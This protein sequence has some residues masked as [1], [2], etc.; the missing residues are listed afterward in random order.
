MYKMASNYRAVVYML[1][2][3]V[4]FTLMQVFVK[5]VSSDIHP[6]Q[7]AFFRN[8]FGL[9]VVLP[10]LFNAGFGVLKTNKISWHFYRSVFQTVG[11]FCFFAALTLSPLAQNVALSFTAPLFTVFLAILLLGE[12]SELRRWLALIVGFFGAWIVIRPGVAE[13]NLGSIFVICSS[14]AWSFSMTIIKFLSK[15]ESS[16]TLTVY[17]GL[18]MAPLSL[19]P[20]IFFWTWPGLQD[21]IYLFLVG[22]FGAT[23]HLALASAFKSGDAGAVLP[24]D[25]LRLIW[26]SV[27]GFII[28]SEVP[29]RWTFIGGGIIFFSATY[30]TL[31]EARQ[32]K[33]KLNKT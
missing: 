26:A 14:I 11:M 23:G 27:L 9:I 13:I 31:K 6:I 32:N 17:M 1:L 24:L 7:V 2:A 20:A 4:I 16:L 22:F 29:D 25:F 10:L 30:I 12:K 19:F 15:T 21:L 18:F 8:F 33:K 5:L 28:F 3:T